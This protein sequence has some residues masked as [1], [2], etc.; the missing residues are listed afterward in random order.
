MCELLGLS[1]NVPTDICF[2]FSTLMQRGGRTGP[3]KDGWGISLY[4]GRRRA[5]LSRPTAKRGLR[6]R[7]ADSAPC[8]QK[9]NHRQP[10]PPC[11]SRSRVCLEN[12]H[13]FTRE[14]WGRSWVFAHNGQ[15]RGI[16]RFALGHYR[17]IGS[18]DSEHAF[19]WMMSRDPR[20]LSRAAAP[21]P[22]VLWKLVAQPG[23]PTGGA[24][25]LQHA[26]VRC[27]A[28]VRLL[29]YPSALADAARAVWQGAFD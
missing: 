17:T 24:G 28:P 22:R 3:H 13:P 15:L 1:A 10:H 2:S 29:Q 20:A 14:L 16:K 21:A 5:F 19:C 4:E 27:D 12:T 9:Q 7:R 26:V 6:S 8:D 23:R 25:Y 11:Q 18:T